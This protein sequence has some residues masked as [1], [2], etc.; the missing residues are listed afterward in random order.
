MKK[1]FLALAIA[2]AGVIGIAAPAS[3]GGYV[4]AEV[5]VNGEASPINGCTD[6]P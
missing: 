2:I 6:L 4:C 3:A 5:F 1:L